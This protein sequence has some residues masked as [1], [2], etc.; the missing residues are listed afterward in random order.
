MPEDQPT[1]PLA[2]ELQFQKAEFTPTRCTLCRADIGDIYYHLGGSKICK[3][4]AAQKQATQEP[5]R[6]RVFGKS[7]LYGL[8]AAAAGSA[9]Y[10]VVLLTTGAEFALLSILVG[11]MVGKAMM[12]GSGGCGGRKFQIVAVLLTYGSITT[13]YVPSILKGLYQKPPKIEASTEPPSPA[14]IRTEAFVKT[15][16]GKLVAAVVF[17]AFIVGLALVS[18]FLMITQGFSG[19]LGIVILFFGL[20]RAWIKTRGDDRILMGPYPSTALTPS[21]ASA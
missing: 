1:A 21:A 6:G 9:L 15:P 14:L 5:V 17:L 8:G 4:C 11:I 3:V 18:P 12:H 7:V 16:L 2:D 19:I 10:G 13:G 20:Q